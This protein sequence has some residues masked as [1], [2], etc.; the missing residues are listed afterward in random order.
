MKWL[1][2]NIWWIGSQSSVND[3]ARNVII[4]DVDNSKSSDTDICKNNFLVLGE[5]TTDDIMTVLVQQGKSLVL[6]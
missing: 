1:W 4:F 2:N 6:I 5:R 3:F